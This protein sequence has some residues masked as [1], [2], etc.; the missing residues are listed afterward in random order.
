MA[1]KMSKIS[2]RFRKMMTFVYHMDDEKTCHVSE[3]VMLI[4]FKLVR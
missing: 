3:N 2:L 1:K 4:F